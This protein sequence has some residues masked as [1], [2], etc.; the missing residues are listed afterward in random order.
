MSNPAF[1]DAAALA[2][3]AKLLR[4]AADRLDR[5]SLLVTEAEAKIICD[6]L[7]PSTHELGAKLAEVQEGNWMQIPPPSRE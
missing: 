7:E 2:D 5:L 1:G 3:L 4:V 6:L